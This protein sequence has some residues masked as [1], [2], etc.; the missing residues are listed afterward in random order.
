MITAEE[1]RIKTKERLDELY[2]DELRKVE[3]AI[4]EAI[5]EGEYNCYIGN[6]WI[7]ITAKIEL[8]KLGYEV[9]RHTFQEDSNE[10]YSII[11]WS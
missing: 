10:S 7:S 6:F 2:K 4:N 11:R 8:E 3:L 5:N 9:E 1:A